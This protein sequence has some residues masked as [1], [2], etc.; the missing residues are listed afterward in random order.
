MYSALMAY[1][2]KTDRGTILAA[3]LSQVEHEGLESLAIR[4][5]A[6][7]LGLAPNAL[8]RYFENLTA[9][10][11]AVAEEARTQLLEAMEAVIGRK[12]PAEAIRSLSAAYLRF[13]LDRPNLFALY[14][15]TYGA[16]EHTPQCVK[17]TEFFL[18]H[19]SKV[20]GEKRAGDASHVLWAFLHGCAML[21]D[22]GL[23][24]EEST[25]ANLRLGLQLWTDGARKAR[26]TNVHRASSR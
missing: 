18:K 9:L 3:A 24:T 13:A 23:V 17:N 4:A 25:F 20:Y 15:K 26:V 16:E 10:K 5:V 12:G 21:L 6:A 11:A 8:Y 22:A 2:A 14:L 1:P 7:K 19:V